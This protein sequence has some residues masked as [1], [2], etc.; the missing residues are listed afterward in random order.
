[1]P[2]KSNGHPIIVA[3]LLIG[4]NETGMSYFRSIGMSRGTVSAVMPLG[5]RLSKVNFRQVPSA[6]PIFFEDLEIDTDSQKYFWTHYS[7]GFSISLGRVNSRAYFGLHRVYI[8]RA[9]RDD[10]G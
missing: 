1:M 10:C 5:R 4:L 9:P 8:E 7:R 3:G 6:I 2:H